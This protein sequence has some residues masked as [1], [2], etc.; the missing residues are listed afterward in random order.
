MFRNLRD[1]DGNLLCK[2]AEDRSRIQVKVR[3][4]GKNVT[5]EIDL[6]SLTV[7]PPKPQAATN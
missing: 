3:S 4:K 6:K 1:E 7:L 2:V 5:R